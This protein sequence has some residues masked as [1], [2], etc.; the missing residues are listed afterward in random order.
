MCK[1]RIN[2]FTKTLHKLNSKPH[3]QILDALRGVA[4]FFVLWYHVFEAFCTSPIDQR[5]NHSYLAVDFFFILSGFVIGYA[6][7]GRWKSMTTGEFF[8]RRLIRL[9]P[10]VIVG[11][12]L[13]VVTFFIQ[14][15]VQ[16]DGTK[17][18]IPMVVA[19]FL[20]TICML[21]AIPGS[22]PEIRGNGEMF[23][24]NGPNWS[25]FFEYIGNIFYAIFIHKMSN[26]VL[27]VLVAVCGLGVAAFAIGNLS[28][29]GHIGVGWSLL[30]YNLLGGMLRMMFSYSAGLLISR[31]FKPHNIKGSFWI[32]TLLLGILFTMP[33]LGGGRLWINGIY[34]TFCI[35]VAFPIILCIG[36]SGTVKSGRMGTLCRY[37][38]DLSYPVYIIHYPFMYLYYAWVWKK[39][40]TFGETWYVAAGIIIGSIILAYIVLKFYDEPVRKRLAGKFIDMQY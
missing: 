32:C 23:P 24:L 1:R 26:R 19:A 17:T 35:V 15:G 7:D 3:Y 21:P 14:G 9:H 39:G 2:P 13:G 36:A 11:A 29:A 22:G 18:A 40:L 5:F 4:A 6:Y 25:L 10:M 8:K 12:V 34:D 16:W 31:V 27:T 30:D 20:L 38:G 33:H 37:L 28:G